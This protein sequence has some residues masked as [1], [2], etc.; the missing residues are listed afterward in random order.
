[1][2][3][4]AL[5]VLALLA[6]FYLLSKAADFVVGNSSQIAEEFSL[7]LPLIGLAL[8]ILT[9][10]PE[11]SL[12][13][14]SLEHGVPAMSA[15]N[16]LGGIFVVLSLVLGLN[17]IS[18]R[19]VKTDGNWHSLIPLA[20]YLL[21]PAGLALDGG[22]QYF[23]AIIMIVGYLI[24]LAVSY[25][26]KGHGIQINLVTINRKKLA[27]QIFFV[28]LGGLII[29]V[30]SDF[31]VT[32]SLFLL[33]TFNIYPFLVG[34]LVFSIGT[35]LPEISIALTSGKKKAGSLSFSHLSGSAAANVLCLGLFSL[36]GTMVTGAGKGPASWAYGTILLLLFLFLFHSYD[37]G[38]KFSRS[39][40]WFLLV[41]Y[42]IFAALQIFL[43]G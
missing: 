36:G 42:A 17:I 39:E 30:I 33:E 3:I 19:E 13:I 28:L 27:K 37:S 2:I 24:W 10:L 7:P 8:G 20:I 1:M 21:L 4:I 22:F 9:T 32:I 5:A 43:V 11:I 25:F 26:P 38:K 31:I 15:G 41:F 23:D 14:S 16:L 40:G 35:N 18:N 12:G 29:L 6:L 34:I